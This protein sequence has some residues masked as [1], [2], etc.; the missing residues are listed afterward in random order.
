MQAFSESLEVRQFRVGR[1]EKDS[2]IESLERKVDEF[3]KQKTYI[4]EHGSIE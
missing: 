1:A 2:E 3:V 4:M